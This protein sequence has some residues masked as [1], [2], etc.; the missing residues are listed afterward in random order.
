[1]SGEFNLLVGV[2]GAANVINL[3]SYLIALRRLSGLRVQVVMT[4]SARRLLPIET[5]QLVSDAA[6]G[7]GEGNIDPGHARLAR[8]ADRLIVLPATAHTLAQAAHGFAG[9]LLASTLLAH[10][11]AV[12]FFPSM[13][14][15]M[16]HKP[17]V[18]RNVAQLRT[19]G[20]HIADPVMAPSW[21]IAGGSV[22]IG[23]G[24]PSPSQIAG[25]I[26]QIMTPRMTDAATA[27]DAVTV[28]TVDEEAR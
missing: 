18:Q 28:A 27:P 7:E 23:P 6:Y 2:C 14:A 12:I 25:L 26:E 19:D 9:S 22:R 10:P 13:N 21:E 4:A 11:R 3:P 15:E 17:S 20:H 5:V 24:L 8:W 1:V 16:W